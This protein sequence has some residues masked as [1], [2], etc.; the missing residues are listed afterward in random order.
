MAF[1][2]FIALPKNWNFGS[3]RTHP[4]KEEFSVGLGISEETAVAVFLLVMIPSFEIVM[5][6]VFPMQTF[7]HLYALCFILCVN[8]MTP[9]FSRAPLSEKIN[10]VSKSEKGD[11]F[12]DHERL[13]DHSGSCH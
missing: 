4:R 3:V 9:H 13:Y 5:A 10:R 1:V 12:R 11:S 7:Q 8:C 2:K 6:F